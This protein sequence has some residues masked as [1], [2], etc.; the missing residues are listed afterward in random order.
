MWWGLRARAHPRLI[1]GRP[2]R[3]VRKESAGESNSQATRR[4]DQVL[5]TVDSTAAASSPSIY[6]AREPIAGGEA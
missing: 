6:P 5:I 1:A 4:L 3:S 2:W